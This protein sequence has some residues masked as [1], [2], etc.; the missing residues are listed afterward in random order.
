MKIL[1]WVGIGVLAIIV[2]GVI[3]SFFSKDN[4]STSS[5][6]SNQ[7]ASSPSTQ[8]AEK[9]EYAAGEL[10][11]LRNHTLLVKDVNQGYKSGNQFDTP[12]SSENEYVVMTVEFTNTGNDSVDINDF[13]F[14]L[15]DETG[16]QRSTTFGGLVDGR[17]GAVTVAAGGKT[18]GKLV[19]EAKKGSSALKLRYSPGIFGGSAITVKLK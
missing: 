3:G 15:E 19:F 1:K 17:L 6:S 14:K 8:Q 12:S 5:G 16:T 4:S 9:T 13:G 10:I 18:S 2:I 7:Q 11:T